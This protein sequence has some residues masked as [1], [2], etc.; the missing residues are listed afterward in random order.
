MG[1]V[2]IG[3]TRVRSVC[4]DITTLG[5]DA[6]VNAANERLAHGGGVAAAI[7]RAGGPIVQQESDAWVAANGPVRRGAA[8][9][10]SAGAMPAQIVVHVVGP[11]HRPGH[12]NEAHL[13]ETVDAALEAAAGRGMRTIALP[14][15]SAG[16]YGYPQAEATEVIAAECL[17]WA[18]EHPGTLDQIV[19]VGFDQAVADDFSAALAS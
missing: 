12:D 4:A 16:I 8:A 18:A 10:T 13:R 5:V 3:S 7:A 15:I 9:V 1:D 6:I 14:A 11:V 19:L 17:R 2:T